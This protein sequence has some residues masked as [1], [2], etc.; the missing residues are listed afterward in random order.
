MVVLL[1]KTLQL[2]RGMSYW[3]VKLDS[4]K[5]FSELDNSSHF[6]RDVLTM[7]LVART[8]SVEWLEDVVGAGSCAHIQSLTLVTP[9][10]KATVE[11]NEPYSVF[12]LKRGIFALTDGTRHMEAQIIGKLLNRTTG[13]CIAHIWDCRHQILIRNFETTVRDF[14]SW[15]PGTVIAPGQLAYEI[16][17]IRV[18]E[19]SVSDG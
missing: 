13:A 9:A 11:T 14:A 1:D 6:V 5:S 7:A 3:Q 18:E 4:G 12:Q 16:V 19:G 17:G 8:R 2:M 10:G 15:M